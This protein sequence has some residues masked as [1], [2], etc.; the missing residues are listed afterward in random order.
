MQT[1]KQPE[2]ESLI[3]FYVVGV[4]N[5]HGKHIMAVI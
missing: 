1:K 2:F 5:K 4:K 3:F